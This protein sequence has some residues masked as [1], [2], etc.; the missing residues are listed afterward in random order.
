MRVGVSEVTVRGARTGET[1]GGSRLGWFR[2]G[3]GSE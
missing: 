1:N 3:E 2:G